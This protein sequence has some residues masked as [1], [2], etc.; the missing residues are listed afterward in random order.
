[1][2]LSFIDYKTAITIVHLF[3]VVLGAGGAIAS[4]FIFFSSIKDKKITSTELR[5]LRVG[6]RMVWIGVGLLVI[7][8]I[9]IFFT[10][11]INYLQSSKFLSKMAI[12][13]VVIINGIFFHLSHLPHIHRYLG[14]HLPTSSEFMKKS[15]ALLASGAISMVSWSVA[16][17]LGALPSLPF[18]FTEIFTSYLV[19]ITIASAVAIL[20]KN[21]ILGNKS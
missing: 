12:V 15:N 14:Q 7:S 20:S 13:A 8:G 2:D 4:D 16:V 10:D 5:F 21:R 17:V 6:S 1:M 11:P 3:G 9:L 18:S 19:V